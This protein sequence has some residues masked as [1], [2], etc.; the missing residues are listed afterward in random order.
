MLSTKGM[1]HLCHTTFSFCYIFST[2]LFWFIFFLFVFF[3][4]LNYLPFF[5]IQYLSYTC[6][7]PLH[8]LYIYFIYFYY[9]PDLCILC[10]ISILSFIFFLGFSFW[11]FPCLSFPWPFLLPTFCAMNNYNYSTPFQETDTIQNLCSNICFHELA[12]IPNVFLKPENRHHSIF[13]F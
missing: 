7:S 9:L 3:L 12:L 1:P 5:S 6:F 2:Y 10:P 8:T 4:H 11:Q 13:M